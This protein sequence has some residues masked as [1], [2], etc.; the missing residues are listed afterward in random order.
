MSCRH[1]NPAAAAPPSWAKPLENFPRICR[2]RSHRLMHHAVQSHIFH[3]ENCK[4]SACLKSSF[5]C[6]PM[7]H[8]QIQSVNY[9]AI[10]YYLQTS[11]K[12]VHSL[13]NKLTPAWQ[14]F[15]IRC[16]AN[17]RLNLLCN[18]RGVQI[19]CDWWGKSLTAP[20]EWKCVISRR[21]EEE[22]LCPPR[23]HPFLPTRPFSMSFCSSV[24]YKTC[25]Q[26]HKFR[27]KVQLQ[28]SGFFWRLSVLFKHSWVFMKTDKIFIYTR[29]FSKN[30]QFT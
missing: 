16:A 11:M 28:S 10:N 23:H 13:Q 17:T 4:W 9:G 14:F 21:D 26:R 18:R 2:S 8:S 12:N 3:R 19:N 20:L 29:L 27:Q 15:M 30:Y 5:I 7:K 6:H 25:Q 22:K 24:T 1:I